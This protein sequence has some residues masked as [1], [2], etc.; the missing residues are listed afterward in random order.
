MEEVAKLRCLEGIGVSGG[1]GGKGWM[2]ER[3]TAMICGIL[4]G[5]ER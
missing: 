1:Y 5:G 2:G 4:M 3:E